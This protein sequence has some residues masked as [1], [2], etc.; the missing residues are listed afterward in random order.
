M[1]TE[2][3]QPDFI[4]GFNAVAESRKWKEAVWRETAGMTGEELD[5]YFKAG[6]EQC[7]AER[8]ER[9]RK[10]ESAPAAAH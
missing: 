10:E 5:A 8:R 9:E 4:P 1:T 2:N 6:L 3:E 7:F